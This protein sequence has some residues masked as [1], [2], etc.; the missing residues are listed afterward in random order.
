M[1]FLRVKFP[2]QGDHMPQFSRAVPVYIL[3]LKVSWFG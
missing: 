2:D 3:C 1:N